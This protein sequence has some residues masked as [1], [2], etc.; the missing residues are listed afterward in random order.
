MSK[1]SSSKSTPKSYGWTCKYPSFS[2]L[3]KW[4]TPL[5]N[6]GSIGRH[7]S[8]KW[9]KRSRFTPSM[10]GR[11]HPSRIILMTNL[12]KER[13]WLW[14]KISRRK[15]CSRLR[16]QWSMRNRTRTVLMTR[17]WMSSKIGWSLQGRWVSWVFQAEWVKGNQCISLI[18]MRSLKSRAPL[19]FTPKYTLPS[20]SQP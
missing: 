13:L 6:L 18:L 9:S 8:K 14:V 2:G 12:N 20:R 19:S 1:L 7:P 17:E 5:P 15:L 4:S 16:I 11:K 10:S 3:P